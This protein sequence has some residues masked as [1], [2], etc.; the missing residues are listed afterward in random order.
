MIFSVSESFPINFVIFGK[1]AE[2]QERR[3]KETR[4]RRISIDPKHTK[5][6][7]KKSVELIKW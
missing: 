5:N 6:T 4:K 7:K 1:L 2:K 3:K